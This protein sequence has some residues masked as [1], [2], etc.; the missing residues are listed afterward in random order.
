MSAQFFPQ[1]CGQTPVA[2]C[3]IRFGFTVSRRQARR[4]VV[5]NAV[6]RVLRESARHAAEQLQQAAGGR[7]I[8]VLLRLKAALPEAAAASWAHAKN[9]LRREAD[10]LIE[11]LR[12]HLLGIPG[13]EDARAA[14]QTL[15][16]SAI[17]ATEP[18]SAKSR[19]ARQ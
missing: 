16:Q 15:A 17:G 13:R 7:N 1:P 6:K 18:G 3:L 5:R 8:D 9:G 12:A 14:A 4:A 2:A 10:S 19:E 11:Q